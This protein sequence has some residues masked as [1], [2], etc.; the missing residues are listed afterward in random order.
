[1]AAL[2]KGMAY[3]VFVI[4]MEINITGEISDIDYSLMIEDGK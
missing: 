1:M 3:I 4:Q 2:G